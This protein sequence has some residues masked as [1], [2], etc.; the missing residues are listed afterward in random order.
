MVITTSSVLFRFFL[1]LE[2]KRCCFVSVDPM[3]LILG[4]LRILKP[5]YKLSRGPV[6]IYLARG[7]K[8]PLIPPVSYPTATNTLNMK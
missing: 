6:Y 2:Q 7:V 8:S 3:S 1:L 4:D 5:K